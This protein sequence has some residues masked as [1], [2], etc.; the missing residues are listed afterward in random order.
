MR[1]VRQIG[2]EHYGLA[3]AL[4]LASMIFMM[5]FPEGEW[6]YLIALNLQALA[7]FAS[8]R[9]AQPDF[10]LR[11]AVGLLIGAILFVAWVQAGFSN[12]VDESFV[13][14]ATLA[15]VLIAT[16]VITWG[17]IR[18]VKSRGRITIHTMMGVLCIYLLMSLAFSAAFAAIASVSGDPFFTQGA[19]WD[20]ADNYLYYSLTTITTVGMGDL[21]PA[22][23]LGR[24]LTAAEALIGQIYVI[25]V[26]AA[27]VANLRP[28]KSNG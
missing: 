3:L 23:S 15:L 17:L 24:S 21:S 27:I 6:A 16:P 8:T 19:K 25:T 20:R 26:V 2:A 14:V 18:Q 12:D 28:G 13:H 1:Q 7:L 11:V 10:R 5:A 4:I 9:A 22:T